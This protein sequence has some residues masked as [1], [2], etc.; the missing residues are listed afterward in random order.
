[1]RASVA[2]GAFAV[3]ALALLACATRNSG[4]NVAM[5]TGIDWHLVDV[6]GQPAVPADVA[7]RPWLHFDDSSRVFGSGGCNRATG[8]YTLSGTSIRIGPLA[9]T[10]M[11]C[12]DTALTRQ[13][14]QFLSTL[15]AVDRVETRGDTL[16]LSKGSERLV[17]MAR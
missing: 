15:D 12:L 2:L 10:K 1:M 4:G 3:L 9:A 16:V 7:K 11:A 14:D 13:E 17:T 8:G 6:R 5:L